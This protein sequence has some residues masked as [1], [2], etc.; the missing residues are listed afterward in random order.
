MDEQN[1]R[2]FLD[3]EQEG[4]EKLVLAHKD[5]LIYFI[6]RYVK[7][8]N[9]AED[10]AQDAFVEIYIHKERFHFKSSF[11]TYLFTIGRNKAVDYIRKADRQVLTEEVVFSETAYGEETALEDTIIANEEKKLLNTAMKQLKKEYQ[12]VLDLVY[13][14]EMSHKETAAVL[15][16]TTPQ[17][18]VLVHRGRKAL[19][20]IL[21]KEGYVHE[22]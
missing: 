10:L 6:H 22:K 2:A 12:E 13:L 5:N 9:Q 1:Y 7:D 19:G 8:L 14:Q 4:F 17:I 11:K 3:G 18:K 15:H 21:E 16:K 20:K